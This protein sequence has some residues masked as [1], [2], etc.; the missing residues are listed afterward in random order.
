MEGYLKNI[1]SELN[2][3]VE[4]PNE[5]NKLDSSCLTNLSTMVIR[6]IYDHNHK[7]LEQLRNELTPIAA[8]LRNWLED[9]PESYQKATEV[10]VMSATVNGFL[11]I[12]EHDDP[13]SAAKLINNGEAILETLTQIDKSDVQINTIQENW[14]HPS[15]PPSVSTISRA[16]G[17]LEEA[18]FVQRYGKTKGRKIKLL[19]KAIHWRKLT[20]SDDLKGQSRDDTVFAGVGLSERDHWEIVP[21]I[22]S[23]AVNFPQEIRG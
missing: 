5:I 4:N 6:E 14:T 7:K 18:G 3:W 19:P 22:V 1:M 16:L 15:E 21:I 17:A 2:A 23:N 10:S 13:Q 12:M 9:V 11:F 8:Q 20:H